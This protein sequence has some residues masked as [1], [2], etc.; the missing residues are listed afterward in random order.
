MLEIGVREKW[1]YKDQVIYSIKYL[2]P[3]PNSMVASF[4]VGIW[5]ITS[6]LAKVVWFIL[7]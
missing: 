6:G 1:V 3:R 4:P 7:M 5:V 2:G